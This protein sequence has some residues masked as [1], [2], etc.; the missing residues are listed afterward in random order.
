MR[1]DN[2]DGLDLLPLDTGEVTVVFATI[3]SSA[4]SPPNPTISIYVRSPL[5]DPALTRRRR[6]DA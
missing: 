3:A 1:N 4:V 6:R 2:P 5:G